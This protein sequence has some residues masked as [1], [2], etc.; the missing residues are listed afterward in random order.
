MAAVTH[1]AAFLEAFLNEEVEKGDVHV[2]RVVGG[3]H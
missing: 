3:D 1:A 2:G